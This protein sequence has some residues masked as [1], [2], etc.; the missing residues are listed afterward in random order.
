M[1]RGLAPAS[2]RVCCVRAARMCMHARPVFL[3]HMHTGC[4][5]GRIRVCITCIRDLCVSRIRIRVCRIHPARLCASCRRVRV[6]RIHTSRRAALP[7]GYAYADAYPARAWAGKRIAGLESF[8]LAS[9]PAPTRENTVQ[10]R[11]R[12]RIP[13]PTAFA[14]AASQCAGALHTCS[15]A[16]VLCA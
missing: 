1:H 8:A 7:A 2:Q 11:E 6:C 5:A 15:A 9:V 14:F 4:F 10:E 12:E 3:P 13:A 16:Q